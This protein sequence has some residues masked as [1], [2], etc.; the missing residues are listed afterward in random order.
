MPEIA[1]RKS[2]GFFSMQM[3]FLEV[4]LVCVYFEERA[5][6]SVSVQARRLRRMSHAQET[7]AEDRRRFP[8]AL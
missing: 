1:S 6:P 8:N 3:F 4:G 2:I 5:R 7:R